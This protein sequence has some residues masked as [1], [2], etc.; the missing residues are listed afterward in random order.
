MAGFGQFAMQPSQV[1]SAQTKN[2]GAN[3]NDPNSLMAAMMG[4]TPDVNQGWNMSRSSQFHPMGGGLGGGDA[5]SQGGGGG[6][7]FSGSESAGA[8]FGTSGQGQKIA[9]LAGAIPQA[10]K[11]QRFNTLL[12]YFQGQM[13]A[14][15]Q[16]GGTSSAAPAVSAAPIW[17]EQ[18]I[19]QQ[20]NSMKGTSDASTATQNRDTAASLAGRGLGG[21]S[22]LL[23]ALTG[24]ANMA[25]LMNKTGQEQSTRWGAAQGNAEQVLK[26]QTEQVN[27]WND[28]MQQDIARRQVNQGGRNAL[29]AA[30]A[31]MA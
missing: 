18:Q 10:A 11:H 8:N 1:M 28:A 4:T 27:A 6:Y 5:T 25:N 15:G 24:Q 17:N 16:V 21:Q 23:S 22:P 9:G 29:I 12:P 20:V 7:A 31:G 13:G 2:P 30:M 14:A 26:G 19:Q 3:F